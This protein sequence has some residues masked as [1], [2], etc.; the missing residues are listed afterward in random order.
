[1]NKFPLKKDVWYRLRDDRT[2]RVNGVAGFEDFSLGVMV[3]SQVQSS[4]SVQVMT[5]ITLNLLAR[6]CRKLKVR[7]P[8]N[9]PSYL[10]YHQSQNLKELLAKALSDIDP[11]GQFDF[12]DSKIDDCNQILIIGQP[13]RSEELNNK[14]CLWIDG[15]GWIAGVGHGSPSTYLEPSKED[16]PI[17]P[18]FASC[19]GV[20]EI[21][22]QAIGLSPSRARSVW[23]S[24]Y[25]FS[26]IERQNRLESPKYVSQ[27]DFGRIHQVGC[28][29]VASSLDFLISLTRWKAKAHL[30]D[31]DQVNVTNCNR[32]L[33]FSAYDAVT[34]K[35]KVDACADALRSSGIRP[36][37]FKGSYAEFIQEKRFLD[38]PPDLIL[39]LANEKNVWANIQHN[40]PP[41]VFHATTT[42][43]WGV[44]FGRHIPKVEWCIMCRFSKEI[45][46]KFSP[47]CSEVEIKGE[48]NHRKPIQGVLP[49]LSATAAVLILA[50]MAKMPRDDYPINED[51]VEF[52]TRDLDTSFLTIQRTPENGC[53]CNEQTV[54][55]YPKEVKSSRFW[56]LSAMPKHNPKNIRKLWQK[57][58]DKTAR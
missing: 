13:E 54:D 32:S 15:A 42:P 46:H 18:A 43:N 5:V 16:N 21:F 49:F 7:M 8:S 27:F 3:N 2:R 25:D 38:F 31:Y 19:L 23:Y 47:V 53:L 10:P 51:F 48:N 36:I 30:I 28:G 39:C 24:L 34:R 22:R 11:Y 14:Q 52:S 50:E 57:E 33:S 37:K 58:V 55:L 29:A 35:D 6:W 9:V 26:K 20:A 44:N 40:L 12:S 56:G 45:E 41:I 17:G 4:Y 1:M